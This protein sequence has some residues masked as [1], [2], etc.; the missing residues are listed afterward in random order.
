M[1]LCTLTCRLTHI[2]YQHVGVH[3]QARTRNTHR[4]ITKSQ[5]PPS[6]E[7]RLTCLH[8]PCFKSRSSL[9]ERC[10]TFRGHEGAVSISM[11]KLSEEIVKLERADVLVGK[12][13]DKIGTVHP[14]PPR[15]AKEFDVLLDTAEHVQ[16]LLN[17]ANYVR[18]FKKHPDTKQPIT[19]AEVKE[20]TTRVST[21]AEGL[22][23]DAKSA[24]VH[25]PKVDK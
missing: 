21:A 3:M 1:T 19:R 15:L 11:D 13:I 5:S 16:T 12:L 6:Y 10:P 4:F 20:W 23:M 14:R 22:I 25:V 8:P 2:D 24:R 18:R 9:Q 17:N 7:L